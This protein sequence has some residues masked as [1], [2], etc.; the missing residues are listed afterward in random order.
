MN[1]S[2]YIGASGM[3]GLSQGMQVT[4]NN[5]ANVSTIGYKQQNVLF[6]DLISQNQAAN[7]DWWNAQEDS[8]VAVGQVGMGLQ[9]EAVR[10]IFTEGALEST[11]SMTD[12][13]ISG[14]GFF[15]VSDDA[16]RTYY[17]RAGDF[18]TDDEG[19]WRTPSG[20]A[21][22]GY[23]IESDGSRGELG[24]VQVDKFGA[25]AGKATSSVQLSLNFADTADYSTGEEN[26]YFS[27]LGQYDA[28]A[29][30]PLSSGQYSTSQQLTLYDEN[31]NSHKVTA[32]FDGAPGANGQK[33]MEFVIGDDEIAKFDEE[34]NPLPLEEGDGLLMA[35][36]LE[37]DS[38]GNL[39]NI[40][41]FTPSEPGNKDLANWVTADMQ[42]GNPAFL[43]GEN[44]IAM[45]FGLSAA[46]EWANSPGSAASIG[47]DA[48]KLPTLGEEAVASDFPTTA[49]ASSSMTNSYKQDGYSEGTISNLAVNSD[50]RIVG[51]F[52]NGQSMD[53]W[54]I[55]VARFTSEDGLYREGGNLFSAT[56]ASGTMEL[57]TAGTENYGSIMAYNIE[58]SN[59]DMAQEFVNMIMTQRGFQSNSK[60]VTT[61]DEVL[62]KAMEIKR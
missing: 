57:G 61:A 12:L 28:T 53:L 10:T 1:S 32:Y 6:S 33:F 15:Q 45:N 20:L 36:V 59:V 35:G 17:T 43:L 30:R 24:P 8:R 58:N 41:A 21:L 14:K 18:V 4:S 37:F 60:V 39:V 40:S 2:L 27:L 42:D 38:A 51:Y 44:A 55:P 62:K 22:N 13:A 56:E 3:K 54:E 25:M 9:V 11:N 5:L 26:P 48:S 47:A 19:V 29:E 23:K 50:G 16:G 34:G 49:F 31:G 7:G 52:S 46:G